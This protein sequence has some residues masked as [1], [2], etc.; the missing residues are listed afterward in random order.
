MKKLWPEAG[1]PGLVGRLIITD[2]SPQLTLPHLLARP[3]PLATTC[4]PSLP[5]RAPHASLSDQMSGKGSG[6]CCHFQVQ[7]KS[8]LWD[9]RFGFPSSCTTGLGSTTQEYGEQCTWKEIE[10]S[11]NSSL[12][13]SSPTHQLFWGSVVP[14]G[15]LRDVHVVKQWIGPLVK[16]Q[17][18]PCV[19]FLSF[20]ISLTLCPHSCC[21]VNKRGT[22]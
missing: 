2:P 12:F 4:Y 1:E 16:P 5:G 21:S 9:R 8:V 7:R 15:L 10:E 19:C 22:V 3:W 6:S 18:P 13:S 11:Q 17:P 20:T 14:N